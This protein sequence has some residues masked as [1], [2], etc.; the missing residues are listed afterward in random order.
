MGGYIVNNVLM[1]LNC[2]LSFCLFTL[3]ALFNFPAD[4]TIFDDSDE[5]LKLQILL[6]IF[7]HA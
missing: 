5:K 7:L 3:E 1:Y 4:L 6:Y 2:L